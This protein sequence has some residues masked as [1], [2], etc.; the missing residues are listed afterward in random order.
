MKAVGIIR[1]STE[2]QANEGV[3]LD[4]QR[5]KIEGYAAFADLELVEIAEDAGVSVKTVNRPGLQRALDLVRRGKVQAVVVTKLD[6]LSRRT[7]EHHGELH[8][9]DGREGEGRELQ[10]PSDVGRSKAVNL[11]E[12]KWYT[13]NSPPSPSKPST[14]SNGSRKYALLRSVSVSRIG[15]DSTVST[16]AGSPSAGLLLFLSPSF[17]LTSWPGTNSSF[18]QSASYRL[19]STPTV[20]ATSCPN[21]G[22]VVRARFSRSSTRRSRSSSPS[23]ASSFLR[24]S[25]ATLLPST[26][27]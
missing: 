12:S 21:A 17:H 25:S 11:R 3:S 5:A 22:A 8:R 19:R 24:A 10:L 2:E 7:A 9:F 13:T 1:V 26:V 23:P 16:M 15:S 4:A 6:R 18:V 14:M 27:G 20:L